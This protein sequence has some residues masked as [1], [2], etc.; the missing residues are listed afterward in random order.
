MGWWGEGKEG[1]KKGKE[2]NSNEEISPL[3][4]LKSRK[5]DK[6]KDEEGNKS[7]G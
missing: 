5:H 6:Q 4:K 3:R 2:K 1:G 7:S